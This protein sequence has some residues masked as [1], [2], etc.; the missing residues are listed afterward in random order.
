MQRQHPRMAAAAAAA[1]A[2]ATAAAA[3]AAGREP[4]GS[5]GVGVGSGSSGSSSRICNGLPTCR[6]GNTRIGDCRCSRLWAAG[7]SGGGGGGGGGGGAG[8]YQHSLFCQGA[9]AMKGILARLFLVIF[10]V[11]AA[12]LASNFRLISPHRTIPLAIPFMRPKV[13]PPARTRR[14]MLTVAA[15]RGLLCRCRRGDATAPPE[16]R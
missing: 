2:A 8:D 9:H 7:G 16:H 15:I 4:A 14:L 13:T 12:C 11:I 5:C 1:A 3:A 10:V 6:H